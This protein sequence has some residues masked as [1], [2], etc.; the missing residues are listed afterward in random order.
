MWRVEEALDGAVG[1]W[2]F[3]WVTILSSGL[4]C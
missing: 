1:C 4:V 3:G 2:E